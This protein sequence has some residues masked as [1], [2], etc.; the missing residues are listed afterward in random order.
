MAPIESPLPLSPALVGGTTRYVAGDEML[1]LTVLNALANVRVRL[2]GRFLNLEGRI[3]SFAHDLLPTSDRV[4]T[5]LTRSLGEG[6][7]LDWSVVAIAAAPVIG[8]AYAIVSLV[9]G[10]TGAVVDLATLG[11]GYVTTT[12]RLASTDASVAS[13]LDGAGA[14]RSIAGTTPAAGV[15]VSETVPTNARWE[16][17]A[18]KAQLVTAVAVANRVPSLTLDDGATVYYRTSCGF[19]QT[20]SSTFIW[21]WGPGVNALAPVANSQLQETLPV[22]LR[23]PA[24]HRINTVTG[25]LQG[26]DQWNAIQY[27]VREWIEGA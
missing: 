5:T 13:S 3:V 16:I 24:G 7:L 4:A 22:G 12:Q 20:A 27:L 6:W 17:L 8:Q 11:A 21:S 1:R 25:A 19:L 15:E 18:F 2:A 10:Q 14:L 26:A 9:R 23:L